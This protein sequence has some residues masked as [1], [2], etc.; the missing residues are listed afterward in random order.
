MARKI[1]EERRD[2]I[3]PDIGVDPRL[4]PPPRRRWYSR[5]ERYVEGHPVRRGPSAWPILLGLL[6]AG[7]IGAGLYYYYW[8]DRS[9]NSDISTLSDRSK[10]A[11]TTAA[12]K[13]QLE[14]NKE[15]SDDEINVDTSNGLVTLNGVVNAA[16]DKQVAEQLARNTRGVTNVQNNLAITEAAQTQEKVKDLEM[17]AKDL[18]TQNKVI[19][20]IYS[21][22]TLRGQDIKARVKDQVVT[23][24]GEVDTPEQK[25]TAVSAARQVS[26]VRQVQDQG[27]RVS[28]DQPYQQPAA[29]P[30]Q[31]PL[32][33]TE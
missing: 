21:N 10:D 17:Q 30:P 23:L 13:T 20:S 7:A 4:A 8:G 28:Y 26:G 5:R 11:A 18:E 9:I 16:Q 25:N 32:Q 6:I 31:P 22:D 29:P 14:L 12:V 3:D 15:L 27:L 24:E 19:E 1:I 33:P 2:D